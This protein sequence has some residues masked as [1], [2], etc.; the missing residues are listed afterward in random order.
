MT[1]SLFTSRID[2]MS[3]RLVLDYGRMLG[4]ATGGRG[5]DPQRFDSLADT[6]RE[7][8]ADVAARR[9]AGK[10]GFFELPYERAIVDQIRSFGEG[11]GQ[12]FQNI[13]V[14]GIGG[15]ALGTTALQHALL[16]PHWN[17][18]DDEARD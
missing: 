10:L 8:H 13:A 4:P 3:D 1:V 2:G 18:L 12:S 5:V 16:R 11:L 6:F 7:V 14:L 15:S 9:A 17:E